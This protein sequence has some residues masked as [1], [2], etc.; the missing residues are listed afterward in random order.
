MTRLSTDHPGGWYD[1][2]LRNQYY[3]ELI[4]AVEEL[5]ERMRADQDVSPM[6][7]MPWSKP[8]CAPLMRLAWRLVAGFRLPAQRSVVVA[9]NFNRE[10]AG[11][12]MSGS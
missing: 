6:A 12:Q 1:E 8:V 9:D 7:C 2:L 5:Q 4:P 3:D 11:A 10:Q